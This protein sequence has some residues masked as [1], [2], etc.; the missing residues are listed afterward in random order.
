VVA[1]DSIEG[2]FDARAFFVLERI[3]APGVEGA[4]GRGGDRRRDLAFEDD[5]FPVLP[6]G[7]I[8]P[9]DGGE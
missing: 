3:P 8:G 5:T 9:G 1:S 7:G 6:G 4:S 2:G